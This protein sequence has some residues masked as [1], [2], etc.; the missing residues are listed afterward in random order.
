MEALLGR[1]AVLDM[2]RYVWLTVLIHMQFR[3]VD[4]VEDSVRQG[5]AREDPN[6]VRKRF[7]KQYYR[8]KPLKTNTV[9][10]W[11]QCRILFKLVHHCHPAWQPWHLKYVRGDT[12]LSPGA[13]IHHW[14]DVLINKVLQATILSFS[15]SFFSIHFNDKHAFLCF[16]PVSGLEKPSIGTTGDVANQEWQVLV[17]V[18]REGKERENLQSTLIPPKVHNSYLAVM[19]S[20][21]RFPPLPTRHMLG[22]KTFLLKMKGHKAD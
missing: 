17:K 9:C 5:S 1:E 19:G 4:L 6:T 7:I 14:K 20:L 22:F 10:T 15:S 21:T 3:Q 8:G 2:Y 12:I 13:D 16:A 18:K 11:I